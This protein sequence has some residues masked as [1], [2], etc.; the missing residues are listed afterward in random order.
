MKSTIQDV[1]KQLMRQSESNLE[2]KMLTQ[3]HS[4]DTSMQ[5]D[6]SIDFSSHNLSKFLDQETHPVTSPDQ[7]GC[8]LKIQ[9][10]DDNPVTMIQNA[11]TVILS[12]DNNNTP[13]TTLATKAVDELYT[14]IVSFCNVI[15]VFFQPYYPTEVTYDLHNDFMLLVQHMI[16][17]VQEGGKVYECLT[18]LMRVDSQID[19]KDLRE[20]MRLCREYS[21]IDFGIEHDFS[22]T[23]PQNIL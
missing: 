10:N 16:F 15:E 14:L 17:R 11:D 18:V 19:D 4:P 13:K 1:S 9:L 8:D 3:V 12:T 6:E 7:S 22:M 20:K 23:A 21:P 2:V 5:N